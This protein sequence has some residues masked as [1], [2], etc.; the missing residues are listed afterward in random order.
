MIQ[1][2]YDER[3]QVYQTT[4]SEID[5][6]TGAIGGSIVTN[7][8][9][10]EDG[11]LIKT[12]GAQFTKTTYDRLGRAV[13]RYVLAKLNDTTYSDASGVS[14]DD[15][16]EESHTGLDAKTGRPLLQF[17]V[18]RNHNAAPGAGYNALY[19]DSNN[20]T[21]NP[22][23]LNGR[24]QITAMW[25][26]DWD[27]V[28]D[29]VAFGTYGGS[30]FTRTSMSVPSRSDSSLR[31]SYSYDYW[32]RVDYVT[33]PGPT[34]GSTGVVQATVY[35]DLGRKVKTIDNYVNGVPGGGTND[36]E[37]RVVEYAYTNGNM[38]SMTRKIAGGSD[39]VTT[40]TYGTTTSN[41]NVATGHLLLSITYPPVSTG[42]TVT[43][44]YNALSQVAKTTDPSGNIVENTFD[45]G[46]RVTQ[47]YASTIVSGFDSRVEKIVTTYTIRGQVWTV[48][49]QSAGGTVRDEVQFTY[50]GWGNPKT[51]VQDPDSAVSGGS[52]RSAETTTYTW[53]KN[54]TSGGWQSMILTETDQP[55]GV[56]IKPQYGT[57]TTISGLVGRP[58]SLDDDAGKVTI[59]E[60]LYLGVRTVAR[61]N[62]SDVKIS[63][64]I[65]GSGGVS[66]YT[67][68]MD[69]FNRPLVNQW[70]KDN[71]SGNDPAF[72]DFAVTFNRYGQAVTV[73]DNVLL[74]S[75]PTPDR[76]FDQLNAYDLLRRLGERDEGKLSGGS[77]SGQTR[78]EVWTRNQ[79]GK[80]TSNLLSND[81]NSTYTD[82]P[83]N[84]QSWGDIDDNRTYNVRNEL[85]GRSYL[86]YL[87]PSTRHSVTL[88]YDSNGNLTDDGEKY[89][90]KYNPWCQL[91]QVKLR[92]GGSTV[93]ANYT[94]NGLGF[95]ISE[96]T[97]TNK[98]GNSGLPDGDVDALDPVFYI[99]TDMQGRRVATFRSV[100]PSG[101]PTHDTYPKETFIY[102]VAGLMGPSF[103][104]GP[105][106]RDRDIDLL[107]DPTKWA[108]VAAASSRTERR[109]YNSD[110]RGNVVAMVDDA[111]G[112]AAQF[113]YSAGGVP[114]G[115]PLGD[116]DCDFNVNDAKTGTTDY[117]LVT[118]MK[119]AGY[120]VRGDLNLDGSITSADENIVDDHG[121]D[122]AGR[123]TL[124]TAA[125]NSRWS[126]GGMEWIAS[127]SLLLHRAQFLNPVL[128]LNLSVCYAGFGFCKSG[129]TADSLLIL[130]Q[131]SPTVP[132]AREECEPVNLSPELTPSDGQNE[133]EIW[134]FPVPVWPL[135][136]H[137]AP[138]CCKWVEGQRICTS[139]GLWPTNPRN[140]FDW[141]P[142]R[143]CRNYPND[144]PYDAPTDTGN[145]DMTLRSTYRS[146]TACGCLE[147]TWGDNQT[148][149]WTYNM[150]NCNSNW[151]ANSMLRCCLGDGVAKLPACATAADRCCIDDWLPRQ[152]GERRLYSNCP[153][154]TCA[155]DQGMRFTK[156]CNSSMGRSP[157]WRDCPKPSTAPPSQP[158]RSPEP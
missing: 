125:V 41:S 25:Y 130:C 57:L 78:K 30:T 118:A 67:T 44:F 86:D 89:V 154:F 109:Y 85:T 114:L 32:G 90:Y 103:K 93:V 141:G 46:G 64:G 83:P 128:R 14:G 157:E 7:N 51:M 105:A 74:D 19:S 84:S 73:Q 122:V 123:G 24:V 37:D 148:N 48:Q 65:Y 9:Y 11:R 45:A 106:R 101:S 158:T 131:T 16:L 115:I 5:Q 62:Y 6:S 96:Q 18:Q 127:S 129:P 95:R 107:T 58:D 50:D 79:A 55:G 142:V 49:Q 150:T 81:S 47:R 36:V 54:S 149:P 38:T 133:V 152:P 53:A 77:I 39:Q 139:Y 121:G 120:Q 138:R 66:D 98:S 156:E 119:T 13:T 26:D 31:T 42:P 34:G 145:E 99:F 82:G 1:T 87:Y 102:H 12:T 88:T 153:S 104:G 21:M 116:V 135:S 144:L 110:F 72:V 117:T 3:G 92:G 52:G 75:K 143:R 28:T 20:L 40:Y 27:R 59:A 4:Q 137:C 10:D 155:N 60:Y 111:G 112:L 8:W 97:D 100:D 17:T 147:Q 136:C 61:I 22:S 43:Y 56:V 151:F 63:N 2:V 126:F 113:R 68:Y 69:V 70:V 76:R 146:P 124:N 33:D 29:S 15:V 35:D 94:Y 140:P 71:A 91:V 134:C 80:A 132:T 108:R 23:Y